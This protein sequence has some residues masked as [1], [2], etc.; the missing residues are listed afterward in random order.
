MPL[1]TRGSC[2]AW[3]WRVEA[4]LRKTGIRKRRPKMTD[5]DP[6]SDTFEE[7]DRLARRREWRWWWIATGV[8]AVLIV[9]WHE[10]FGTR[11]GIPAGLAAL[12]LCS[13][14]AAGPIFWR[15][16]SLGITM[17]VAT[18]LLPIALRMLLMVGALGLVVGTKWSHADS[19]AGSLIGSYC[20]FLPLESVLSIRFYSSQTRR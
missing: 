15:R 4:T 3:G 18:P 14:N 17:P 20:V 2:G 5:F 8:C 19:F 12:G 11:S 13:V 7:R 9:G 10:L 1:G 16:G 6:T